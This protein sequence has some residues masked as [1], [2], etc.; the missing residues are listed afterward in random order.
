ME[1]HQSREAC[2]L[3]TRDRSDDPSATI[4][5]IDEL[6]NLDEELEVRRTR[7]ALRQ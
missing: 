6:P 4:A 3:E 5:K 1:V 7:T 2:K